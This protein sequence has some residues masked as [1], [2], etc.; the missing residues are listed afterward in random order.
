MPVVRLLRKA[1][2][3][4]ISIA[5]LLSYF[6]AQ[7]IA[8]SNVN[9]STKVVAIN[10]P[11]RVYSKASTQ[12]SILKNY[13]YGSILNVQKHSKNWYKATVSVN[14]KRKTGYIQRT[15]L[16]NTK[17]TLSGYTLKNTTYVY[18]KTSKKAKK[19]KSF[20]KG[21]LIK[22]H[23]YNSHWFK[24]KV[25][26]KGKTKTGYI[27]TNDVRPNLTLTGYAQKSPTYVY[28]NTSK[29]AS[30]LKKYNNGNKLS[31]KPYNNDWYITTVTVNGKTRD[32]YIYAKDIGNNPP[33]T[34]PATKTTS[35]NHTSLTAEEQKMLSLINNERK[36][37]KLHE[38]KINMSLTKIARLKAKDMID[39]NYFDHHS[40]TYG[41]PSEMVMQFGISYQRLG[42]NLAGAQTVEKAHT[43][44]MNSP[45]HRA[46]ILNREYTEIG[47]GIVN[48]GP[49]GKMF[50]QLFRKP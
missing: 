37:L 25:K 44:L 43:N 7:T 27:S 32:G 21:Q 10:K 39:K 5:L 40:P 35:A 24:V 19:L 45:G 22:Y 26:V 36:K 14:G 46:N 18:S 34:K 47:I 38:L 11:T 23:P 6:P 12:S 30:K 9:I 1:S 48:G 49:Y 31:F 50:V 20:K 17:T 13:N 4:I 28:S 42:E 3:F 41:S 29:K 33:T 16:K 8:K 15:D 2:I